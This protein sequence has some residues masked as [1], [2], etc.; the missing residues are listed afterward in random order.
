MRS[1]INIIRVIT[2]ERERWFGHVVRTGEIRS[3]QNVVRKPSEKRPFGRSEC[4]WK[5]NLTMYVKE[6]GC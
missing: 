5:S 4:R 1:F 6:T 3:L 2:A